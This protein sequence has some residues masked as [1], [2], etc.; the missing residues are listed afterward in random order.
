MSNLTEFEQR[1]KVLEELRRRGVDPFDAPKFVPTHHATALLAAYQAAEG[2]GAAA[3]AAVEGGTY[4]VAGRVVLNRRQGKAGFFHLQDQSG[5]IQVYCRQ[6]GVGEKA[7][8]DYKALYVGDWVGVEGGLMK[9]KT[10]ETTVAAR[11]FSILSKALRPPPEKFHGLQDKEARYRQRYLDLIANA[12]VRETFFRRSRIFQVIRRFLDERGFLEVENPTLHTMAGGAEARPFVTHHNALGMDIYLRIA[13]ELHLKRLLVGGFEKVYE[14]GKVFRN[15]GVS[16]RHNPEFTLLE[17]YW[18]Y[19]THEDWMDLSEQ[20]YREI[21]MTA[22]GTTLVKYKGKTLDLGKPWR[23]LTYAEALKTYAKGTDLFALKTREAAVKRANELGVGYEPGASHGKVIDSIFSHFVEE[24]L[25]EPIFIYDYPVPLSPLA[26]RK[27]GTDFL[28]SRFEGYLAHVEVCNSFTE[29][30]DPLD[31]RAR[32]EDQARARQGG[33]DEAM[34]LDEDF[35]A[36]LE[37]GMPPSSG[38]GFGLDR[39]LMIILDQESIRDVI[40]FPHMR[41]AEGRA[42]DAGQESPAPEAQAGSKGRA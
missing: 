22:L 27:T 12:E 33:D 41:P 17:A 32:L 6:D 3:V 10:G 18:A 29:L 7:Y 25:F 2:Q 37:H 26:K 36:A 21:A 19:A 16:P 23:R 14:L 30:N 38:I 20:L 15:E 24:H 28:A 5:R 42:G 11:S 1:K 9:T 39:A 4:K 35:L 8:E 13:H 40:L 34:P 31:Q